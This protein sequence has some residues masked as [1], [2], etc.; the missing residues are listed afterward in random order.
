[1]IILCPLESKNSN[2]KLPTYYASGSGFNGFNNCFR[3]YS[4]DFD[5]NMTSLKDK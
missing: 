4:Y 3:L 1:M 5:V 2:P